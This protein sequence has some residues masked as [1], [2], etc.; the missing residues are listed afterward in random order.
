MSTK[1]MY[2]PR[3]L[4]AAL[5]RFSAM[6]IEE[7]HDISGLSYEALDEHFGFSTGLCLRYRARKRAPQA[8]EIQN[9]EN[10]VARLLK[11]P[12]HV[13]LITGSSKISNGW[14]Q[15][16]SIGVPDVGMNLPDWDDANL[17][18]GYE[19]DW[20]TYRRLKYG[21]VIGGI[22]TIDLYRWQ[23]GCLWDK[24]LLQEPWTRACQGLDADTPIEDFLEKKVS[25]WREQEHRKADEFIVMT[26]TRIFA[27]SSHGLVLFENL[28]FGLNEEILAKLRNLSVR[29]LELVFIHLKRSA[30]MAFADRKIQ[31]DL[32]VRY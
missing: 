26:G 2:K 16:E 19:D 17:Q 6:L 12:A 8:D 22:R 7:A 1:K 3:R 5:R 23:W 4:S 9:L 25:A 20:P 21:R 28:L 32:R 15:C 14:L 10:H 24:G 29:D 11:R 27:G 30:E 18:L 31:N 13:V